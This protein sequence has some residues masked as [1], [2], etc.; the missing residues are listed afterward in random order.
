MSKQLLK[1]LNCGRILVVLIL[2]GLPIQVTIAGLYEY[3][4]PGKHEASAYEYL[5]LFVIFL[6]WYALAFCACFIRNK[7]LLNIGH[8]TARIFVISLCGTFLAGVL[9]ERLSDDLCFANASLFIKGML[10]VAFYYWMIKRRIRYLEQRREVVNQTE[11]QE[12]YTQNY[13]L[14]MWNLFGDMTRKDTHEQ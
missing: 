10:L 11:K 2:L 14:A 4:G 6:L 5:G 1:R 12:P 13:H 3:F 9:L 8:K 7:K